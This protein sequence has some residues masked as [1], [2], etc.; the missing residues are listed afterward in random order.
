MKQKFQYISQAERDSLIRQNA[1]LF[2]VEE[3]NISEGNFLIF[4][5]VPS[6]KT[7]VYTNVPEKDFAE[8]Q[9]EN[10]T[11]KQQLEQTNKDL[12]EFMDFYFS[13]T[14]GV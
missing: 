11:L 14:P 4:S 3:Q 5:D 8:L 6:E 9:T 12:V 1:N 10:T 13:N 2:M 7:V